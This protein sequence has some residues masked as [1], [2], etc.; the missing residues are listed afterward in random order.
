M[1]SEEK[2]PFIPLFVRLNFSEIVS[3]PSGDLSTSF[4]FIFIRQFVSAVGTYIM[5]IYSDFTSALICI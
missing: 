1:T 2:V 5:F 4:G 3:L